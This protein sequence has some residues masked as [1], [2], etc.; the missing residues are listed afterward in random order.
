M[1]A[2]SSYDT[3]VI[4]GG[5]AGLSV[6]YHREAEGAVRHPRRERA[7]RRCLAQALG[8]RLFTPTRFNGLPGMPFD[9]PKWSFPTKDEMADYLE[10]YA[11]RFSPLRTGVR[12]E[13]VAGGGTLHRVDRRRAAGG[14]ERRR[15]HGRAAS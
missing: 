6:G 4:G 10:A 12:V 13:S 15:R 11:E 9:A 7:R 14:A 8:L 5:Q 3:I 2:D 1:N